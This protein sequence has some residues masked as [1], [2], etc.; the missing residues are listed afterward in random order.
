MYSL[1]MVFS[2]RSEIIKIGIKMINRQEK[3][4]IY[5]S[6]KLCSCTITISIDV[7]IDR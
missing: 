4:R 7:Y 6:E 2:Y 3:V 5:F 1:E